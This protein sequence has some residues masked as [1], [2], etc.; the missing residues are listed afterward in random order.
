MDNFYNARAVAITLKFMKTD[1]VGTLCL[2]RKDVPQ[3]VKDNKLRKG[4]IIAPHSGPASVLKWCDQKNVTM[5]STYHDDE[6]RKVKTKREEGKQIYFS[7]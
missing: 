1:C 6:M 2:N 3:I 5:I 4:E 7:S